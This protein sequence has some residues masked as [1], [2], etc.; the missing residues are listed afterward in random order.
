MKP[1]V[2]WIL[3]AN[4]RAGRVLEHTGPGKGLT[5]LGGQEWTA[6]KPRAHRDKAGVGHS[7]AGP[8][9]A[10]VEQPNLQK[11]NDAQFAKQ[12]IE[13]LSKAFRVKKFDRLILIA[14][15]HMLGLLRQELGAPLCAVLVG[16]IPKDLSLRPLSEVE[17]HLGE[18]IV[19]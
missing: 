17:R 10:A 5:P 8:G 14:G 13:H 12:L 15:P 7:I 9:V 1:I 18:L 3:L 16:E 11:L 2:T 19:T 6:D 4:A